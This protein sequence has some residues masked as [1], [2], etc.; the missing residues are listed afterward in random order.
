MRIVFR[1][2]KRTDR[3]IIG[4]YN[5][6]RC[7]KLL[8]CFEIHIVCLAIFQPP[9][10]QI[11]ILNLPC[12]LIYPGRNAQSTCQSHKKDIPGSLVSNGSSPY[13]NRRHG[14]ALR[15]QLIVNTNIFFAPGYQQLRIL[16]IA[17]CI[18]SRH[19]LL[20]K[21]LIRSQHLIAHAWIEN[22]RIVIISTRSNCRIMKMIQQYFQRYI[23]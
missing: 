19:C 7:P 16:T 1:I 3:T 21:L 9:V 10:S 20:K 14:N 2:V 22:R 4:P 13:T 23:T 15:V 8:C 17:F 6:R 12:H 5:R 18:G 11:L